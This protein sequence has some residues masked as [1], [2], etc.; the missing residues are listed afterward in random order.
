MFKIIITSLVLTVGIIPH[1]SIASESKKL[2]L[3][4]VCSTLEN[5]SQ[6]LIEYE[7]EPV[8]TM[9]TARESKKGD[10]IPNATVFFMNPKTKSWTL[11]EQFTKDDYCVIAM[12]DQVEPYY[13]DKFKKQNRKNM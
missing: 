5:V 6:I 1:P 9:V 12:G 4:V 3:D 10:M 11:V 7:E 13:S 2:Y 8:L